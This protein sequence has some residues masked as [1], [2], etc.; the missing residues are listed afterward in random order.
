MRGLL[1]WFC[2]SFTAN[3]WPVT[4]SI[5]LATC[6]AA[7]TAL[8]PCFLLICSG[9]YQLL[10]GSSG[11]GAVLCLICGN[12]QRAT[13]LIDWSTRRARVCAGRCRA[14]DTGLHKF[15]WRSGSFCNR[16]CSHRVAGANA[17]IF[18]GRLADSL[19]RF[20]EQVE[21]SISATGLAKLDLLSPSDPMAVLY[22]VVPGG[23]AEVGRTEVIGK[24]FPPLFAHCSPS[25]HTH[26]L[27]VVPQPTTH[28]PS[29]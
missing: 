11:Q 6:C 4:G 7:S 23:M 1:L 10:C 8:I 2:V 14:G 24:R 5:A 15:R 21:L 28:H 12:F 22:Q 19:Y 27:P 25:P 29:S 13:M 9:L 16:W 26:T 20:V 18:E 3:S 17:V